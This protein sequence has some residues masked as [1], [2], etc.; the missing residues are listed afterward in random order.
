ME[1]EK[2]EMRRKV[3]AA[4]VCDEDARTPY[5]KKRNKVDVS[6]KR[7]KRPFR[8]SFNSYTSSCPT[9]RVLYN[10]Q[11]YDEKV[12]WNCDLCGPLQIG[13]AVRRTMVK[14]QRDFT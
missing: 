7:E 11:Y 13:I 3:A 5:Y 1:N 9:M 8:I 2:K 10:T 14:I 12:E 4:H 6:L